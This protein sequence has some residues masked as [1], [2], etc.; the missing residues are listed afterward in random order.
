MTGPLQNTNDRA[1]ADEA[2][3]DFVSRLSEQQKM[4][5]VLK[6][7]LYDGC[8]AAMLDDLRNRLTGKPYIF[9]L[10]N[11]IKDDIET[12]EQLQAFEL[13]HKVDLAHF[14]ELAH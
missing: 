11:R 14:V 10:V 9:K 13:E 8:W 4:L 3:S 2:V 1:G 5:I 12:I 7:K 6:S